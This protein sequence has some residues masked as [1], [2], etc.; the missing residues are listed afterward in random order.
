MKLSNTRLAEHILTHI[1]QHEPVSRVP[2]TSTSTVARL[3][4]ELRNAGIVERRGRRYALT[5]TGKTATEHL[6]KFNRA[7]A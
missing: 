6:R 5:P 2:N 7:L 3:L 4:T 1:E